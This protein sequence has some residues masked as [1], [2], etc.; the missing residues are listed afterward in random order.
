MTTDAY[1]DVVA[2]YQARGRPH[3]D[4]ANSFVA[5]LRAKCR[6]DVEATHVV[7][8]DAESPVT[9]A[10]YVSIQRPVIVSFEPLVV[11]DVTQIGWYT[12]NK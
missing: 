1:D 8:D 4:F 7:F 6:R 12:V 5:N 3:P 10:N 11:H 2:F 9:S